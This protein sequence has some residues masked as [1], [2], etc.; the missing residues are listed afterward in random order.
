MSVRS[1]PPFSI[2][3][4]LSFFFS[5][6]F[7]TFYLGE[8][9]RFRCTALSPRNFLSAPFLNCARDRPSCGQLAENSRENRRFSLRNAFRGAFTRK[10][11]TTAS[12]ECRG[13]LISARIF[14]RMVRQTE[15][16][17]SRIA[18]HN[19]RRV[20]PPRRECIVTLFQPT[21]IDEIETMKTLTNN[22]EKKMHFRGETAI[23]SDNFS[24]NE[25]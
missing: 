8:Y 17:V 25:N 4:L 3:I 22:D 15:K 23:Q 19:H 9:V 14:R 5:W 11:N 7:H 18:R 12:Y 13:S 20:V 10:R 21:R 1:R 16:Q 2:S 6:R 24:C